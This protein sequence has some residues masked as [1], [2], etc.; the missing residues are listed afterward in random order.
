MAKIEKYVDIS[1]DEDLKKEVTEMS[2]LGQ[3]IYDRGMQQGIQQGLI[4]GM[5]SL[6][7]KNAI[8]TKLAAQQCNMTEEA[9]LK[10]KPMYQQMLS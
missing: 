8:G 2:G 1:D 6:V 10:T 9:F 4:Q 5:W 3:T 7:N